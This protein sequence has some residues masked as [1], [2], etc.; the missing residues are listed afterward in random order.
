MITFNDILTLGGV[1]PSKVKILR[2]GQLGD[3][4]AYD[5]WRNVRGFLGKAR[6][7]RDP[8]GR[9]GRQ[10]RRQ[11]SRQDY[12]RW[13]VQDLWLCLSA[14]WGRVPDDRGSQQG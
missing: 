3:H 2:H 14:D 9:T 8:R 1:A 10:L 7:E 12:L 5:T 6:P 4:Q 11:Q 13:H